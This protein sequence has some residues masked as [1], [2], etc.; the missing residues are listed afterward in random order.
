MENTR[1]LIIFAIAANILPVHASAMPCEC[2][3]S[4]EKMTVTD[5]CNKI[6]RKLMEALQILKFWF[7]K[8]F[9]LSFTHGTAPEDELKEMEG[10]AHA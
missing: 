1:Y 9:S 8:G 10:F 4:S 7:K 3:F 6:A 5:R 2:V